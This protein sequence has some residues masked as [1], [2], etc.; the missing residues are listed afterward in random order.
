[1]HKVIATANPKGGVG[2]TTTIIN[3]SA[4]LALAG[5]KV[6]IITDALSKKVKSVIYDVLVEPTTEEAKKRYDFEELASVET[7]VVQYRCEECGILI[8]V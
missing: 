7:S 8:D 4:S 3:L 5:K 1:M 2:K 6:L